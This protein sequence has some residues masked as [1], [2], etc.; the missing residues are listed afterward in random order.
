MWLA[1]AASWTV[2]TAT[3]TAQPP[4][5]AP[6]R[7]GFERQRRELVDEA[8][9]GAG[10]NDARVVRSMLNTPRHEFV[11]ANLRAQA[12]LDMALP[13]GESQTISSPFIVS[14]MTQSLDPQPTDTVLEIGTGSGYQAAVLSPLVKHVYTIEI[15][16]SL[17][18]RAE[19]TLRRLGY[20]NVTVKVGDGF[21]GWPEHAPFDKII[22]T[23]SP[24]DIPQPL[25]DQLRDGGLMVIPAGTR[26]QQTLYLLRKQGGQLKSEAL[27]PTLFV[28]MTGAA[29]ERRQQQPDPLRP[30]VV[31]GDFE[32]PPIRENFIP[33]WYYQ[34]Q[35]QWVSDNDSASEPR[36][37]ATQPDGR[38]HYVVLANTEPGRPAHLLQG[39]AIDGRHVRRVTVSC[40]ARLEGVAT[41]RTRDEAAMVALTFY[42]SQRRTLGNVWIGPLEGTQSWHQLSKQFAV[43]P[44]TTE[45]ILRLGLFGATGKLALDD[46]RLE[47]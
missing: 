4:S 31:N 16:D 26:Y 35:L 38:N 18:R 46:V 40:R 11:P 9:L 12:Y 41:G 10:V 13:I 2:L 30:Q 20:D 7:D 1:C 22:V 21:Q 29:E 25:I 44:Q 39:F 37:D 17:G 27:R 47:P 34:R 6:P 33:G 36:P 8:I 32:Q 14:Y 3:A 24:E 19:R 28:P 45:A 15:V 5:S 43:P 42:D 23:C